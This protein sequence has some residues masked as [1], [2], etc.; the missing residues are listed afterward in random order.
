MSTGN[1]NKVITLA[2]LAEFETKM[3]DREAELEI[4]CAPKPDLLW[5]L[6]RGNRSVY[7]NNRDPSDLVAEVMY[8]FINPADLPGMGSSAGTLESLFRRVAI[9]IGTKNVMVSYRKKGMGK[10]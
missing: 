7:G 3:A 10:E 9:P 1:D 8:F 6:L 2:D 5:E 4:N